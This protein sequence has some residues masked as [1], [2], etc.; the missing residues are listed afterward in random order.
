MASCGCRCIRCGS[1]SMSSRRVGDAHADGERDIHHT[2]GSCNA[3]F[4]HLEGDVFESC[5]E[6]GYAA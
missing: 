4:D 1:T 3:H 6:C 2:C 5:A